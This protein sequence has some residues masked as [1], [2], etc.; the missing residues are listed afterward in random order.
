MTYSLLLVYRLYGGVLQV[1]EERRLPMLL[2][3]DISGAFEDDFD[4]G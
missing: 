2:H 3:N 4:N 1:I